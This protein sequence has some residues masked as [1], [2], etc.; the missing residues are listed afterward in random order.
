[1]EG[2]APEEAHRGEQPERRHDDG[3]ERD[4]LADPAR[5]R[6]HRS[7]R[8]VQ[9]I[10]MLSS[11]TYQSRANRV[12]RAATAGSMKI[13]VVGSGDRRARRGLCARPARARR[14]RVRAGRP[15]PA[16]TPTP[17]SHDGLALDTGFLV[18]NERNYPLLAGSSRELGV[19]THESDM[20]FSVS[21]AGCG[22]EY[23]GRRPSR[24]RRTRRARL[25]ALLWEIGRWLRTA[26]RRSSTATGEPRSRDYLD[27]HGYSQRFRRHFLVPL[28]VGAVVDGARSR[29]RVPRRVRD[30]LLRQP[31]DARLRTLPLAHRDRRE[32]PLRRRDR[33]SG[34][35]ERLQLG[36]GVR[37]LAARRGRR[38]SCAPSTARSQRFDRVVV[39][40]HADQALALLED[41]T[42]DERRV[43]GALR[44]H[45]ERGRPPHRLALPAPAA[46]R[47]ARPGTTALGDDGRPTITYHLNRLQALDDGARLLRDAERGR[48]RRARARAVRLRRIR[49]S[50][51]TTLRA[52]RELPALAGGRTPLRR[53]VLR[54]RL[55]RGRPRERRRRGARARG[56]VV[57]RP[58]TPGTLMHA[59][60]APRAQRLPLPGLD[61]AVRPRRAPELERRL[62][63]F[64]VNGRNVVDAPRRA[65]TSTAPRRSSRPCS[66]SPAT[67]RSSACSCSRSRACSATSSTRS[68]STGATAATARSR[69]WSPS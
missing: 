23:S 50:P 26:G 69:A 63:L 52:Q 43:L 9:A 7:R 46:P 36:R 18:H 34:S 61:V 37:S 21:C 12:R 66:S 67:R 30:P 2:D 5:P 64:S 15:R 49:S 58:S 22:L 35:A 38:S 45:A 14:R 4:D 62:R 51:S 28:D 55:P 19:A 25:L 47:R 6:A 31:R 33:A 10:S 11:S 27:V 68:A 8:A 16:G 1:M 53:R 44:L 39:A 20:S 29:A 40:T 24:S 13:A 41:P 3:D 56:R 57:S 17:S 42:P 65:T 32:P 60:R 54:Q 48:R 59:R